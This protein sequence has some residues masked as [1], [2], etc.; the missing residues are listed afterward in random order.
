[1]SKTKLVVVVVVAVFLFVC[2]FLFCF[3]FLARAN[4]RRCVR[5]ADSSKEKV[6]LYKY[7]C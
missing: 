7:F 1:M 6:K 4:V 5:L 3:V 2:L